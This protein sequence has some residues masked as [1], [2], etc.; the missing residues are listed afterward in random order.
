METCTRINLEIINGAR[1]G[2]NTE[3]G[4]DINI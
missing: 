2:H 4:T 3:S 1:T